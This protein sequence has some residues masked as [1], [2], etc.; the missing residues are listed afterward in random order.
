MTADALEHEADA[1]AAHGDHLRAR[2]LLQQVTT[3]DRS[4]FDPWLKLAAMCRATGDLNAALAAIDGALGVSPLDFS[5]LLMRATLIDAMGHSDAAGEAFGRAVAQA[6]HPLPPQLAPIVDK[7]RVHYAAWQDKQ[8]RMLRSKVENPSPAIENMI[9]V[10]VR[11]APPDR[12]GPTH[13][14]YPGLPEISFYDRDL[15]PWLAELEAETDAIAAEFAAVAAAHAAELV[16]YI[17][18][19]ETVPLDQ[20]R[21]LN[22]NRDW[23][24]IHLIARGHVVAANAQHCSKTMQL[25]R[26][27]P[28]PEIPG[29][30]PNA[31]FSLLAPHTHIPAHTGIA[32]TRLV[33]HLPLI[34]PSGCWFRVGSDV[35]EWAK[36]QAWVFDDTVEHEAMNPSDALRVILIVD[37]WHPDLS[38]GERASVAAVVAAGGQV[39]GL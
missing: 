27:I 24:A 30:G 19:P 15:F 21:A 12:E 5:A 32:N 18:Y 7:A 8:A 38:E 36:G 13:Y 34:V 26:N 1:A 37:C 39:H 22:H 9:E 17:Q 29:A 4:R 35:R 10:A 25:L 23:T 20:W 14:C 6:P 11:R 3:L 16:P 33:C 31:M 28:Q 2:A